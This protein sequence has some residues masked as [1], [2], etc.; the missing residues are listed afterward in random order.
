MSKMPKTRTGPKKRQLPKAFYQERRAS[1]WVSHKVCE[2]CSEDHP[3]E[4]FRLDVRQPDGLGRYCSDCRQ[5]PGSV[6]YQQGWQDRNFHR[7][8]VKKGSSGQVVSRSAII[9]RDEAVCYL[10]GFAAELQDIEIEHKTPVGRGG[11]H[12]PDNL[13][14]SHWWCNDSKSGKTE[15]EYREWLLTH[16][17]IVD[18]RLA[19]G[20]PAGKSA[21]PEL[22]ERLLRELGEARTEAKRRAN[23]YR[24]GAR[25][26]LRAL[27]IERDGD[28]CYICGREDLGDDLMIGLRVPPSKG[29]LRVTENMVVVCEPCRN[30]KGNKTVEEY[31]Q[32]LIDQAALPPKPAPRVSR[33]VVMVSP[34]QSPLWPFV[35]VDLLGPTGNNIVSRHADRNVAQRSGV[36]GARSRSRKSGEPPY[37]DA[38][39]VPSRPIPA[40]SDPKWASWTHRLRTA[41]YRSLGEPRLVLA[42]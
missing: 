1:L 23:N 5:L 17:S 29:G 11:S 33:F 9:Q 8:A 18:R 6:L 31:E 40:S 13:A 20:L 35:V 30:R 14:V 21:T 16:V 19:A 12:S 15:A 27:I 37:L 42:A 38:S 22:L 4:D 28:S 3:Q 25:D 26:R 10:C 39:D 2:H 24:I 41:G 34:Y 36:Y 7:R 32:Y